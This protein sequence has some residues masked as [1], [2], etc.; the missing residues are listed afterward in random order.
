MVA[1]KKRK[2]VTS[3][4]PKNIGKNIKITRSKAMNKKKIYHPTLD[5]VVVE[6]LQKNSEFTDSYLKHAL[7]EFEKDGD[8]KV[9]LIILRQIALAQ[10]GGFAAL[11]K[12]T[13]FSR[14]TLYKTLSAKGNPTFSTLKSILEALGCTMSFHVLKKAN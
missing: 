2:K 12:K 14:E 9:F 8:E 4:K 5:E 7:E 10:K 6:M 1:I 3:K 13:G 11:A